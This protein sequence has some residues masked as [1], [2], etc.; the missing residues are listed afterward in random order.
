M[1]DSAPI[2]AIA[3]A[4]GR[5]GIGVVRISGRGLLKVA[6]EAIGRE[7]VARMAQRLVM[8][9]ASGSAID[10]GLLLWFPGPASYTGEDVIEFHGHGGPVVLQRIQQRW[11]EMVVG[12]R[13]AAP[14]EFTERAFLNGKLDLVQAEAVADLIDASSLQAA[15]S[16][17]RS[18]QGV[19][20]N[21]V[22]ALVQ[23]L[24][25]L[26]LLV[27]A[28]LDFPEEEIEFL[29]SAGA[30]EKLAALHTELEAVIGAAKQGAALRQGLDVVLVGEPNVG[31]SS[32]LNA[33]AGDEV[34]IVTPIAGTTRDRIVQPMVM[35][36]ALL[37]VI[38]TAGLR[39]TDDEVEQMGIARTRAAI[40]QAD[41][42]LVLSDAR[43]GAI[44]GAGTAEVIREV[45]ELAPQAL[46]LQVANKIDLLEKP[47]MDQPG[48]MLVSAKTGAGL[49]ELRERL[50]ALVGLGSTQEDVFSA[51]E[52]HVQALLQARL[53]LEHAAAQGAQGDEAL[54]LVAEELRLAQRELSRITGEFTADDLLGEIFGRFCIGK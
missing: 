33:L 52:R 12:S 37:N 50:L 10:D 51:R 15:S 32:L 27:E 7:P 38:D 20:S 49:D 9:D 39:T 41:V 25:D 1:N 21:K 4:A 6:R 28:T 2:V 31:K 35:S 23:G 5:G 45:I 53:H 13:L 24:I 29:R 26:R 54:D 14:G 44:L 46:R 17:V 16:A 8:S 40:A 43:D 18:L 48:L 34:A 30:L 47:V 42:V 11:L 3:T 22:R 36:G 19:F